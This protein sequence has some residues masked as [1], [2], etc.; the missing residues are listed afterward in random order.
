MS[1][2]KMRNA[3]NSL[4][5]KLL[6][7]LIAVA[8]VISGMAGY[9][10]ATT[11]TSAVKVNGEEIS[12]QLFQQRYNDEYQRLSQ[13]LGAQ[14]SAVADTPEF[15]TG[16]R[17]SVLNNLVDQELVRQYASGLKL[18]VSD[19]RIKQEIVN[20][21]AFQ[22]EGK[23]NNELYQQTLRSNGMTTDSY[24]AYLREALR[25]DQLQV[26]LSGTEFLLPAQQE[27]FTKQIFQKRT[28]R[29][30]NL[31]LTAEIAKQNVTEQEIVDYYNTNKTAF[32]VPELVKV[33]Y[34]DLTKESASKLVNV[35]DVEIQQYYQDNKAQ[36][37]S[38]NQEHLSH[39]QFANENDAL[40]A[41]QALQA[42]ADFATL[43]KEK[44]LDKPSAAHGGDLGWVNANDLPKAFTDATASL[45]VNQYS[46]PVKVDNNYHIIKLI[47][48]KTA[49]AL[50][51]EEVKDQIANQ[52]RQE[53]LNNQF[54]SIEKQVAE[55]AFEDQSSL[56]A[57]AK[58][59]GLKVKETD[60]FSRKDIPEA[61]NFPSVANAIF[62][63]EVSQGGQNSE[64]MNV[65]DQHSIVVRVV[66]H[67]PEG[68][69]S[70]EDSKAEIKAFLARQKAENAVLTQANNIVEALEKGQQP[71]SLN[72]GA[73]ET[74]VYAENKDP[75]LND[76]IFSMAKPDAGKTSYKAAKANNGDVMIIALSA[77]ENGQVS[78]QQRQQFT[79]QVMRAQQAELQTNLLKSLRSKAKIEVNEEFMKQSQE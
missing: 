70:L 65:A 15:L 19:A 18:A 51:L 36:F 62:D 72:F 43:A 49:N 30:A 17:K 40:D 32:M 10:V 23:F 60:Y 68:I 55:K 74:W 5:S 12:Q 11:D 1:M 9:M 4:F 76:V 52:I 34:L 45:S 24:A 38:K 31:P 41:Y 67:K 64:P 39:I 7:G 8:F 13:Q 6:F 26:G 3:S 59:A 61:L 63:G 37:I 48:R 79:A 42:G 73:S 28:V 54:Y 21:P 66:E 29:L 2:E 75:V 77:V 33:Q 27:Q 47:E 78:E 69:K 20:T 71:T 35:T 58:V 46:T 22:K 50:S 57:A 56:E 14:F 16:L 25:L 53:L 44:S